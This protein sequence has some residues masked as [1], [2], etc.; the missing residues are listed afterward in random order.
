[1]PVEIH[2]TRA[3]ELTAVRHVHQQ[4]FDGRSNEARLVELLHADED[5]M[6]SEWTKAQRFRR[7]PWHG[8]VSTG[9]CGDRLL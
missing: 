7:H 4:A 9:V 8:E 5:F 1:M 3:E 6:V 2:P